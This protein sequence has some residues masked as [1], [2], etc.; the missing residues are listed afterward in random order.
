[1]STKKP[2]T[3]SNVLALDSSDTKTTQSRTKTR[4]KS[5]ARSRMPRIDMEQPRANYYFADRMQGYGLKPLRTNEL[6]SLY[7]L[8][9]W[10]A[11]EQGS[12][13]ETVRSMTET[14]F[15]VKDV[16]SL[17]QK[18]YDEVIKFLV[19]LRIDELRH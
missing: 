3:G 5:A 8:F 15:C 17:K 4:R 6:Q 11:N 12:A 18:D 9:A 10:I 14:K 13:P 19:D 2:E 7:A 1:M 16:T